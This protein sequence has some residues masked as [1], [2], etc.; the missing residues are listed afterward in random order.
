MVEGGMKCTK[1]LLF[2]FNIIF[3][4]AGI[5]LIVAGAVVQVKFKDYL[6]VIGGQFGSAAALLIAVGAIIFIIAFFGCCGA[7]KENYICVMIFAVLLIIIFILEIAGGIA[8]YVLHG[9]VEE[10]LKK[11]LTD[12]Q[13]QFSPNSTENF[14]KD[15]QPR[16]KCCG[17]NSYAD[18][19]TN[20]NNYEN[21]TVP[22]SCC[23]E[24]ATSCSG[25]Q[26]DVPGNIYTQGC[27]QGFGQFVKD[28]IFIIGG[29]G[30]GLAFVQIV[31]ILFACCLARALKK[32]YEVV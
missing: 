25:A 23:K 6:T 1:I 29:V 32:E 30:I 7:W 16:F 12:S 27:V 15:V 3:V 26:S 17:V 14:W 9:K 5:G 19:A 21:N 13:K 10:E 4:I 31:G 24:T 28:N 22:K 20:N 11:V 18:W 8:G 2:L